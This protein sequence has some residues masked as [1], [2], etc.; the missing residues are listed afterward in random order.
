MLVNQLIIWKTGKI[1]IYS[2]FPLWMI[3]LGNQIVAVGK[4][5]LIEVFKPI[6]EEVMIELEYHY[7]ATPSEIMELGIDHQS[8]LM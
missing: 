6:N 2:A 3:L 7:F 5:L 8:L 4:F 1:G